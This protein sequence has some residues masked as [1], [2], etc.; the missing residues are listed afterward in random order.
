MR[1]LKRLCEERTNIWLAYDAHSIGPTN[2]RSVGRS[3]W[4]D[5]LCF[6]SRTLSQNF[7]N[8]CTFTKC[9]AIDLKLKHAHHVRMFSLLIGWLVGWL[10]GRLVYCLISGSLFLSNSILLWYR[11]RFN[12]G[13]WVVI[14]RSNEHKFESAARIN[15]NKNDHSVTNTRWYVNMNAKKKT[16]A[17]DYNYWAHN[18]FPH[19]VTVVAWI[20]ALFA[21]DDASVCS[22]GNRF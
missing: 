8:A 16:S 7:L 13:Y 17:Y 1:L 11:F 12:F 9:D 22:L 2:R 6:C 21:N 4:L 10:T 3:V 15:R 19:Y 18:R 20:S 14:L 5:S